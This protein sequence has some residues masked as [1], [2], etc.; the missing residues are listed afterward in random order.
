MIFNKADILLPDI[1]DYR[2]WAVIACDQFTSQPDYWKEIQESVKD[3][4]ST[5]HL[6]LPEA[7]LSENN[8]AR[9]ANIN[10]TMEQYLK[11]RV[12]NCYK[13]SYIYVERQLEN[14][15]IRKGIIG[16]IDLE[17]YDYNPDAV[18][19]IRAT[20][21]TVIERI[22]PRVRIR[23]NARLELP[24]ILLLCDD[25]RQKLIDSVRDLKSSLPVLY[26]FDLMQN[27][28]HITGWL[29]TGPHAAIFDKALEQYLKETKEKYRELKE[30]PMYFAVGDGNHSLATAKEC[31][32]HQKAKSGSGI[33]AH[34]ALVELRSEERR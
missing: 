1:E 30:A 31:Y 11:D 23:E 12:F 33:K 21:K 28:G 10:A 24:H 22:P 15:M 29:V 6:I 13:D 8:D 19:G 18:S 3:S 2:K 16:A 34:Y 20:E 5:L 17:D 7:E 9:I 14:G 32:E 26:D 4:L 27:G 25:P